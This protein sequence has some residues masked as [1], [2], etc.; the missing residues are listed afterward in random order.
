MP[1]ETQWQDD[2]VTHRCSEE[3]GVSDLVN[4][5]RNVVTD[6][7]F[8]GVNA[9]IWEFRGSKL[10]VSYESLLTSASSFLTLTKEDAEVSKDS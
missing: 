3:I 6:D 5:L 1:I 7:R 4:A 8:D 2:I 10:G 9:S